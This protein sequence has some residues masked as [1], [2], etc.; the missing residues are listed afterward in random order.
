MAS[1]Q[2]ITIRVG[3][4]VFF[5]QVQGIKDVMYISTKSSQI[6]SNHGFPIQI[7]QRKN[8]SETMPNLIQRV[9]FTSAILSLKEGLRCGVLFFNLSVTFLR[10]TE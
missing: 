8:I 3:P 6:R 9:V 1:T 5:H 10:C 2:P 4:F 7:T